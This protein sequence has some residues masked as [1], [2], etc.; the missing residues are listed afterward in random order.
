MSSELIGRAG[1]AADKEKLRRQAGYARHAGV[2]RAAVEG[3]QPR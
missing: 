3:V 1:K 2:F